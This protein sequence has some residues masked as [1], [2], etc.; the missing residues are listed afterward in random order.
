MPRPPLVL[1]SRSPIFPPSFTAH[2]VRDTSTY[3]MIA[4]SV[5]D[6]YHIVQPMKRFLSHLVSLLEALPLSPGEGEGKRSMLG[7]SSAYQR[8]LYKT[9]LKRGFTVDWIA[10]NANTFVS[11]ESKARLQV[12]PWESLCGNLWQCRH[13]PFT[14][15]HLGGRYLREYKT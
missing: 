10:S 11:S 6:T 12:V 5:S 14:F 8:F 4:S 13:I 15:A 2:T 9:V 7:N 1:D 3:V